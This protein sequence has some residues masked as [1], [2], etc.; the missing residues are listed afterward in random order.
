M[1][2]LAAIILVHSWY[3]G[4]CCGDR[5]C[6]PVPCSEITLR[7]SN[8]DDAA[9][10]DGMKISKYGIFNSQ[11]DQCHACVHLGRNGY[12]NLYCVFMPKA[13]S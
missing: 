12:H 10:Y 13:I 7:D 2:L 11:D 4:Q 9:E 8:G 1:K 6:R 3:P 5:D